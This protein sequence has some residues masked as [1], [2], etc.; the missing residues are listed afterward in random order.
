MKPAT[1]SA[2]VKKNANVDFEAWT[3]FIFF[4]AVSEQYLHFLYRSFLAKAQCYGATGTMSH[5]HIIPSATLCFHIE[6]ENVPIRRGVGRRKKSLPGDA[7][8]IVGLW[9]AAF[10]FVYIVMGLKSCRIE[11]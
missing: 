8:R 10:C 3:N 4:R 1:A 2:P 5:R 6:E 9:P 7:R 11:F